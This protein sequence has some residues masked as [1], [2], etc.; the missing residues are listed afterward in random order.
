MVIFHSYV[1]LPEGNKI[2]VIVEKKQARG[3][4]AGWIWSKGD[5]K[6][7]IVNNSKISY[8]NWPKLWN[9]KPHW[10]MME[11]GGKGLYY[12]IVYNIVMSSFRSA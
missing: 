12:N 7:T 4:L 1:S 9:Q 11:K 2:I 8:L 3:K 6:M 10:E 5:G